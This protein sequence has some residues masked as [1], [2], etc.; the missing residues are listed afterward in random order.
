MIINKYSWRETIEAASGDIRRLSYVVRYSSIPICVPENVSEHSFW[1][2]LYSILIHQRLRP[3]DLQSIGALAVKS[4]THDAV[5]CVTG[6]ILR[7]FKYSSPMLHK[8][9]EEAESKILTDFPES[10]LKVYEALAQ[11]GKDNEAYI[12]AVVKAADFMSLHQ[13][14]TREIL[15]GNR[16]ILRFYGRMED[17]L[18][19]MKETPFGLGEDENRSLSVLYDEMAANAVNLRRELYERSE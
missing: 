14:M 9:I 18:R 4:V 12:R 2:T 6:D 1:V 8:A 5:E 19:S 17:D 16:E 11:L 7:T 10:I 13:Y 3:K 15:R